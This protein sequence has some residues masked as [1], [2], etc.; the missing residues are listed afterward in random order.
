[1]NFKY[2]YQIN[3]FVVLFFGVVLLYPYSL[4]AA[5]TDSETEMEHVSSKEQIASAKI[6]LTDAPVSGPGNTLDTILHYLNK[7]SDE[8]EG[9]FEKLQAG[10]PLV[11]PDLYKVYVTL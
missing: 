5:P 2:L 1:M 6:L 3:F 8:S 4:T 9:A 7:R 11:F 10:I